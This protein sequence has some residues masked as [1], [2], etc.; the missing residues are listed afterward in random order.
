MA[1]IC[2]VIY[3]DIEEWFMASVSSRHMKD[4]IS[5]CL[6]F[7]EID[8]DCYA[9]SWTTTRQAIKGYGYVIF[10][11]MS[12]GFLGIEHMLYVLD[13]KL[14]LLLVATFEDEGYAVVF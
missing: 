7:L 6:N 5:I 3:E 8:R 2:K 12:R 1:S 11:L 9:W 10:H 4:M 13:L 14:N